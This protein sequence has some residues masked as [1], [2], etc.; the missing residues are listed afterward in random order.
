MCSR[1]NCAIWRAVTLVCVGIK[2]ALL[3]RQLTTIKI[4]SY[5][6]LVL[7][8]CTIK[9]IVT[10]FHCCLGI[11]SGLSSPIGCWL[12]ILFLWYKS[13]LRT[14]FCIFLDIFGQK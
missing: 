12:A 8:S 9:F 13:Q 11:L 6:F 7:G 3:K 2:C 1:N 5:P 14:Y 10:C 4:E